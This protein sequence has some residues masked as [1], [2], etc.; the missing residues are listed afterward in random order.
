M[1]K[2]GQSV[3]SGSQMTSLCHQ[4]KHNNHCSN[5]LMEDSYLLSTTFFLARQYMKQFQLL[6]LNNFSFLLISYYYITIHYYM[7]AGTVA[8]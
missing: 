8:Q 2:C 7:I 6:H 5:Y 3:H 1:E 4:L